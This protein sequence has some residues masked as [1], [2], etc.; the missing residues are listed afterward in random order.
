MTKPGPGGDKGA[1]L[2]SSTPQAKIKTHSV[3]TAQLPAK[4]LSRCSLQFKAIF[5]GLSTLTQGAISL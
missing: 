4:D 2:R 1:M 3:H 5:S